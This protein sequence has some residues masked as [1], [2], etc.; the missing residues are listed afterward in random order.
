M[1]K[2]GLELVSR[3]VRLCLELLERMLIEM[4]SKFCHQDCNIRILYYELESFLNNG[5][6]VL[7]IIYVQQGWNLDYILHQLNRFL[8]TFCRSHLR[9]HMIQ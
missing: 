2:T 3:I 8:E 1:N 4:S 9:I 5:V 6:I 7:E